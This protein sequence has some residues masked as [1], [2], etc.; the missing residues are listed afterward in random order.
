MHLEWQG[1]IGYQ[2]W[3]WVEGWVQDEIEGEN[4]KVNALKI[5]A[6]SSKQTN[7]IS[8]ILI[9]MMEKWKLLSKNETK[10]KY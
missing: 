4:L 9:S 7:K 1:F 10:P 8:S 2:I 3:L 6:K 5:K